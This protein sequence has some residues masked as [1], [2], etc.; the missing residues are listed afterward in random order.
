MD[1]L[2]ITL[3][4]KK[5]GG[6]NTAANFIAGNFLK[7]TRQIDDFRLTKLGQ[8]ELLN[9]SCSNVVVKN[10]DFD[11]FGFADVKFYSFADP[12]KQFCIDTLGLTFE[13]CYGTDDQKNEL[14]HCEKIIA[15][16]NGI[17]DKGKI[18]KETIKEKAT[19]REVMQIFG[20]DMVRSLWTNAW[21]FATYKRI[22]NDGVK[23]AIITDARFPNEVTMGKENGAKVI[24]LLRSPFDDNHPSET[25]LDDFPDETFDAVL[26]NS[27]MSID[28]QNQALEQILSLHFNIKW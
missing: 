20:T 28:E 10:G 14:T 11:K 9:Q 24:K 22:K 23:L 3:A 16:V 4:G 1:Q 7:K 27:A 18:F 17:D 21:A 15:E 2:I 12:L 8:L 25:A 5:G 13:Q 6:K 26:D 19:A